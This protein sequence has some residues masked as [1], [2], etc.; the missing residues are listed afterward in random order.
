[1]VGLFFNDDF[2][3]TFGI[4]YAFTATGL[5]HVSANCGTTSRRRARAARQGRVEDR[6][7]RGTGR[8]GVHR[9][10]RELAR[11]LDY[12]TIVA[13]LQAQNLTIR[14]AGVIETEQERVFLRVTGAFETERDIENVNFVSG[15]RIFRLGDIANVRRELVH[16]PQP[17]FR[18]NGKPTSLLRR[19]RRHPGPREE[20]AQPHGLIRADTSHRDRARAGRRPGG[21]G[22][23][24]DRRL[25]DVAVAGDRHHPGLQLP[26]PRRAS[27]T[28]VALGYP[29]DARDRVRGDGR[30]PPPAPHPLGALIIALALLFYDAM[31]TV[32][33]M[34]RRL[35][36]GDSKDEAATFAYLDAGR[37][38]ADR[39]AGD[40]REL[41][42]F[43]ESSAG[44]YTFSIFAVVA[45]ALLASWPWRPVRAADRK[46][47]LSGPKT[48]T[49]EK[50]SRAAAAYSAFLGA[51][52][53]AR[54]VT[55]GLT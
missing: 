13:T 48:G 47:L 45:I 14:P 40:D 11:R 24:R 42:G 53:R 4:I 33:A 49:V 46:A 10:R 52:I 5:H 28:V 31:T 54:W 38:D 6:G 37:A 27:G 35:G 32:D 34:I 25:H 30:V 16:P 41:I 50:P 51:A 7:A 18:V 2:G 20:R 12:P 15:D 26:E 44:E 3:D 36:A 19:L 43:A 9:V 55:I 39:H 22:R 23:R 21:L 1:M 8:A 17:M 29:P